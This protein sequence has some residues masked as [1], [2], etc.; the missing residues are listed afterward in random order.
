MGIWVDRNFF[1]DQGAETEKALS[2]EL[3]GVTPME[4][5][6]KRFSF[7]DLRPKGPGASPSAGN[8]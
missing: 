6:D 5:R 2:Q 7:F 8:P 4:S 3:P 1:K